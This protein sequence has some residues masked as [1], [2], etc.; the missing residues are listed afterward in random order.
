MLNGHVLTAELPSEPQKR[1]FLY[2]PKCYLPKYH[3]YDD[4]Q[5]KQA[6]WEDP[7]L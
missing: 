5:R 1:T 3:L 2:M 6:E 7:H 4:P